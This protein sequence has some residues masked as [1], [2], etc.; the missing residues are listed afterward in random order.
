GT[1]NMLKHD[2]APD[3]VRTAIFAYNHSWDYVDNVLTWAQRYAAGNFTVVQANGVSCSDND[4]VSKVPSQAV[5]AAIKFAL[6]QAGKPYV[7]GGTG[8]DAFDC[9]GLVQ[10]AYRAAGIDIPRTTFDEWPFGARVPNGQEQPGDLVFFN[11]GP[12]S[13]PT[14]P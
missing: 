13:S 7:W 2:G 8:P 11:S 3:R 6:A 12:G 14:H 4:L 9:S 10:A 5:A 1:A